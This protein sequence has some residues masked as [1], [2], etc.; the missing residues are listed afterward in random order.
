MTAPPVIVAIPARNEVIHIGPCLRALAAQPSAATAIAGVIV[1]A[2]NCTDATAA[3]AA[4][5]VAPF[6]I[7]IISA[8][9]APEHAHIGHARRGA[10]DAALAFMKRGGFDDAIIAGTDADSRAEPGWLAALQAAFSDDVAAVCGAIDLAGPLPPPLAAAL[11]EEAAYAETSARVVAWLDPLAHDPWPNHIWCWGA[12][13]AVRA[14]T[15]VAAGG[16][17]IVDLAEDRALHAELKR[18]DFAVRHSA[19][20]RVRTSARY[21]GR[22]PGGFAQQLVTYANDAQ[23]FADFYLEPAAVTWHR[24]RERGIARRRWGNRPG[25]G[26]WWADHEANRAD[27]TRQRIAIAALTAETSRLRAMLTAA[28]G[29][30]DSSPLA[31]AEPPQRRGAARQ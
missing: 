8:E 31:A 12:N 29:R 11:S 27:L 21:A 13:F 14:S 5:I 10:T 16:S 4:S 20:V 7:E 22:A 18:L 26:A 24:A 25:F 6:P 1:F 3:V 28:S 15:L 30:S 17:P 2:N 23:A 9:L 19:S